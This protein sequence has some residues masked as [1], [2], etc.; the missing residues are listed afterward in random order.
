MTLTFQIEI[1][2]EEIGQPSGRLQTR[3]TGKQIIRYT[4]PLRDRPL[5]M[6]CIFRQF[7]TIPLITHH[8]L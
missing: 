5:M 7:W 2:E 4:F 3:R 8:T 6:S 1:S